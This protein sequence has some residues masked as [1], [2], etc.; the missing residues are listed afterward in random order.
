MQKGWL[1]AVQ[2]AGAAL[3]MHEL[4][5]AVPPQVWRVPQLCVPEIVTHWCASATQVVVCMPVEQNVP[6]APPVQAAGAGLHVQAPAG[7]EPVQVSFAVQA[8]GPALT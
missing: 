1:A 2:P 4:A 6:A 7:A 8:V 5:P 3:Q